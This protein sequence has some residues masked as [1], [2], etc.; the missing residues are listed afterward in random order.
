PYRSYTRRPALYTVSPYTT[1]C[2]SQRG[3]RAV[4]DH[5]VFDT[6]RK[7]HRIKY[8]HQRAHPDVQRFIIEIL[9]HSDYFMV[10]KAF[11]GNTL[12]NGIA[13]THLLYKGLIYNNCPARIS[14]IVFI[15]VA[16]GHKFYFQ[17]RKIIRLNRIE[18]EGTVRCVIIGV[19][20]IYPRTISK[21]V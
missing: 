5:D 2:R 12:T 10:R 8:H 20:Y 11:S 17:Y 18:V 1:L 21:V 14:R 6:G 13:P 3:Y 4:V 9:N 16:T 19:S 7:H 15:E